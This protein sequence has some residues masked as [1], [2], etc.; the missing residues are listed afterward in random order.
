[1]SSSDQHTYINICIKP[2]Q[3]SYRVTTSTVSCTYLYRK[4]IELLNIAWRSLFP[5][6]HETNLFTK[7]CNLNSIYQT[8]NAYADVNMYFTKISFLCIPCTSRKKSH[9][10]LHHRFH[11]IKSFMSQVCSPDK[12]FRGKAILAACNFLRDV[13]GINRYNLLYSVSLSQ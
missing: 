7:T 8:I 13:S 4:N 6:H 3:N 11:P 1:M 10:R 9:I 2:S 12:I 5:S